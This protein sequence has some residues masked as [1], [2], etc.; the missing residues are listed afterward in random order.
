MLTLHDYYVAQNND[1]SMLDDEFRKQSWTTTSAEERTIVL[2]KAFSDAKKRGAERWA[3]KHLSIRNIAPLI[4]VFDGDA[5]GYVSI[6]EAN[7]V[8]SLRPQGWR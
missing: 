1:S 3:L 4:E 8:T 6:W 7:Q 2:S 5:S